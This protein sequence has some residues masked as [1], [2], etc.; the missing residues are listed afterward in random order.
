MSCNDTWLFVPATRTDRIVKAVNS[1]ASHII[2]DLE[3]AVSLDDKQLARDNIAQ[4]DANHNIDYWLRINNDN[5]CEYNKDLALIPTLQHVLGVLLP[6]TSSYDEIVNLHST[7]KLPVIAIIETATGW[8][9]LDTIAAAKGLQAL[10][11][12]RLDLANDL[13]LMAHAPAAERIFDCLRAKLIVKSARHHLQPPIESVF[14]DFTNDEGLAGY[15]KCWQ[16]MGFSGQLCIHPRQV[17]VIQHS[18]AVDAEDL[19][20]AQA[21]LQKYAQTKTAAFSVQGKMVDLPVIEW[22]KKIVAHTTN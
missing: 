21:V 15:A 8:D 5:Q 11:Y 10:T 6:K 4:F 19:A 13:G 7:T 9:N 17:G 22:A 12:G 1:N 18:L 3:D 20:F 2:V 14:A 16:Q